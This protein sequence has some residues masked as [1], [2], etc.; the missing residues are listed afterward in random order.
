MPVA[1]ALVLN[2]VNYRDYDRMVTLLSPT[3]G[4][5]DAVARGCRKPK[6]PLMNAT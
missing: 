2:H 6:S 4:R 1:D 3:L 5:V